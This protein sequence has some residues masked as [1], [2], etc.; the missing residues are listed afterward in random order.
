M[1]TL[2][3]N[4]QSSQALEAGTGGT[5]NTMDNGRIGSGYNGEAD[6]S[7]SGSD[8]NDDGKPADGEGRDDSGHDA[9]DNELDSGL[10][11]RLFHTPP[12]PVGSTVRLPFPSPQ[13]LL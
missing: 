9:H 1:R 10:G 13:S 7:D 4:P 2:T 11:K 3:P 6:V 12:M 5:H 8:A